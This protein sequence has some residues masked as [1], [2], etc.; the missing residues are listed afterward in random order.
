MLN[1]K[2]LAAKID[3]QDVQ[4]ALS[5]RFS[6]HKYIL[7]NSFI[8]DW[9]SD[10]L[11]VNE[12]HYIYEVEIKVS[13]SD[14]KKDFV[15]TEKHLLLESASVPQKMPNKFFYACERGLIPSIWVPEYAG[16]IEISHTSTGMGAEVLKNAPFLHR[17]NIFEKIRGQ[18]LDKFYHKYKRTEFENYELT[19][20]IKLL[21][22]KLEQETMK[23][24]QKDEKIIR[25]DDET[26]DRK[27]R[28]EGFSF[29]SKKN[30]K[31]NIRD[32]KPFS[33]K[34]V[35]KEP[36]LTEEQKNY[37]ENWKGGA[38]RTPKKRK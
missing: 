14:Y 5:K 4:Q 20:T 10:Y 17:E 15:K 21:E 19:R 2:T 11:S 16:L 38:Q 9:E 32:L 23:T 26:A 22:S 25:V 3:A 34:M 33:S 30:W 35:E 12:S 31:E 24:V 7:F 18:L 8:F 29:T 1:L 37:V 13:L 36:E 6:D 27:V 28:N